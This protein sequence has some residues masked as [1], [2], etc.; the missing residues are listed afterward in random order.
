MQKTLG[1]MFLILTIAG[2]VL[3]PMGV[4]AQSGSPAVV[5]AILFYSPTCPHCHEVIQNMLIPMLEE[6]GDRLLVIG[7]DTT[8]ENGGF[9]YHNAIEHFQIP[10]ERRGVPTL[11]VNETVLVGSGEIPAPLD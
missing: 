7:V 8:Q 11:I 4:N 1:V 10:E 9:L 6:Y 3:F 5:R 2:A